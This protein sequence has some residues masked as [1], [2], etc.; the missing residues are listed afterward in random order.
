[1]QIVERDLIVRCIKEIEK[2]YFPEHVQAGINLKQRDLEYLIEQIEERSGIKISLSTLKRLWKNEFNNLPHLSTLNGLVSL[3]G[4]DSWSAFKHD[5]PLRRERSNRLRP[6]G[7]LSKPIIYL[8]L[9]IGLTAIIMFIIFSSKSGNNFYIPEDIKLTANKTVVNGVPSSVIFSYDL[10]GAIA[11]SFFIQRSWNP[12]NKTRI[13][14]AK[15][16]YSEI[17]YYPGFHWAKLIANEQ[18]IK[19]TRIHIK[20]VDWFATAK[21][22][23]LDPIPVYL[24]QEDLIQNGCLSISPQNFERSGL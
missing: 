21:Y 5:Q 15:K 19:K 8:G 12:D 9:L 6:Q 23:R 20:T 18:V 11:D 17:Y 7:R 16:H 22:D 1:M 24:D 2:S 3:L 10:K 4:Y 13:D 14:P